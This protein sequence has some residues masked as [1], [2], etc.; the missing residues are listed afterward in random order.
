MA[1]NRTAGSLLDKYFSI[2]A[3]GNINGLKAN[4]TSNYTAAVLSVP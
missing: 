2:K 4:S 1:Q 3:W